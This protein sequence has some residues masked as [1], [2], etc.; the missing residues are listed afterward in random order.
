MASIFIT[1]SNDG[2]GRDAARRLLDAGHEVVGHARS[3]AKA[4]GLRQELPGIADVLIADL[5][6]QAQV[7]QLAVDANAHGTFDA[8]IHNAGVYLESARNETVD[9]H[10][11]VLAV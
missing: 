11:R 1:G 9:G 2:L 7:R 10:A 8:V 4:D 5:S 6:D 3:Q